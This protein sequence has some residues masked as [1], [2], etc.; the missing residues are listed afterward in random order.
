MYL[1]IV[2]KKVLILAVVGSLVLEDHV[3][4]TCFAPGLS[5]GRKSGM[6]VTVTVTVTVMV[7]V[8]LLHKEENEIVESEANPWR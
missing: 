4:I 7:M 8:V 2:A 5:R 3:T 1:I 6:M